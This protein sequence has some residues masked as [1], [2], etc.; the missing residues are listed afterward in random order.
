MAANKKD[1]REVDSTGNKAVVLVL[2]FAWGSP[3]PTMAEGVAVEVSRRD[4]EP[5][6]AMVLGEVGV[7]PEGRQAAWLQGVR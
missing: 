7:N 1:I 6:L 2:A 3:L 4:R 5:T